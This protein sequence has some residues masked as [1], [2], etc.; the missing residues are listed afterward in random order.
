MSCNV[1]LILLTLLLIK[2]KILI[3]QQTCLTQFIASLTES[4][5]IDSFLAATFD[6]ANQD[7]INDWTKH[8]VPEMNWWKKQNTMTH[9]HNHIHE[10]DH[11]LVSKG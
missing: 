1:I 4:L 3:P 10:S 8:S 7:F 6:F 5:T 2:V 11:S 9:I